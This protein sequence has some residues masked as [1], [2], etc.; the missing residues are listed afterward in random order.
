MKE[1]E[2][3]DLNVDDEFTLNDVEYKKTPEQ[4]ISCCKYLNAIEK[5]NPGNKIQVRPQTKV[6][7]ND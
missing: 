1:V 6:Q 2:F 3:K 7:I 5:N 4:R